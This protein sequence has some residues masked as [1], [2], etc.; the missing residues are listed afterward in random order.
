MLQV[1]VLGP[2]EIVRDDRV[3]RLSG[4]GQRAVLAV[5]A[6]EHGRMVPVER[7]IDT[8]WGAGPPTTARTKIQGHISALRKAIGQSARHDGGPLLTARAGYALSGPDVRV[9]LST[10]SSLTAEARAAVNSKPSAAS[11]RFAAALALWRGPAFA[12]VTAS[13]IRAVA[14]ATEERRLLTIEAKAE[15]DLAV[16]HCDTVVA[17]VSAWLAALPLRERLRA[18]LMVALYRLGCRSDALNV[19]LEGRRVMIAEL[20][21]EPSPQLRSLHQRILAGDSAL[22]TAAG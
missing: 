21:I 13:A 20:G 16:G 8:L 9:D 2:V 19:Y 1:N 17:E 12:D 11:E 4:W 10:F 14:G 7:L 18:L 15:A 3:I 22:L 5:L 6:L